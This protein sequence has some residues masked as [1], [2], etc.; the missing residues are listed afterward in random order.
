MR[1]QSLGGN[2]CTISALNI[3]NTNVG[4]VGAAHP[5]TC[6]VAVHWAQDMQS[7]RASVQPFVVLL[8]P[9]TNFI[10]LQRARMGVIKSMR[11]I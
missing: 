8:W 11:P 7:G 2:L 9:S 10:V 3:Q 4:N 1:R 6:I 5:Y